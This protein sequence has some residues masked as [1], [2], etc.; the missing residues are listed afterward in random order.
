M[1]KTITAILCFILVFVSA[2]AH[3]GRTDANG[4][5]WDSSTAE[6]HYHHGYPAHQHT[7]GI[8]PYDYDDQTGVN[9][10]ISSGSSS[11]SSFIL[12][13]SDPYANERGDYGPE[14]ESD[15]ETKRDAH[16]SG[17]ESGIEY[18]LNSDNPDSAF[19]KGYDEGY[20][21]GYSDGETAGYEDGRA[22][23]YQEGSESSDE[24]YNQGYDIGYDDGTKHGESNGYTSG[25]YDAESKYQ[26]IIIIAAAIAIAIICLLMRSL[27]KVNADFSQYQKQHEALRKAYN[28]QSGLFDDERRKW[29]QATQSR[30]TQI[31]YLQSQ[32]AKLQTVP[33]TH[34]ASFGTWKPEVHQSQAQFERYQR[35]LD[36]RLKLIAKSGNN[37]KVQ[38]TSGIYDVTLNNCN[39]PDFL[40]NLHGQSP[41]KHIY[42]LARQCG[43]A[44]NFIFKDFPHDPK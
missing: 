14:A 18:S 24:S 41:C 13:I 17:F 39:C 29:N 4:G 28:E 15:F 40:T 34:N 35:S 5:H 16:I 27:R 44:V 37:Y 1:K 43:I 22:Y 9:S 10:G 32:I 12:T 11:S 20:K 19:S 42:F 33:S 2:S 8:C 23:G 26:W 21:Q 38:G 36:P 30:D 7:D 3:S 6:Y 31:Q 25:Y